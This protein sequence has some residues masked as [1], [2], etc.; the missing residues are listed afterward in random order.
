MNAD[1]NAAENIR[2]IGLEKLGLAVP[3]SLAAGMAVTARG[4]SDDDQAMKREQTT[5]LAPVP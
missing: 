4:A 5:E 1:H 2:R 3:Y